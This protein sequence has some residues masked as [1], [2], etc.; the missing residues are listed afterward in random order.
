MLSVKQLSIFIQHQPIVK[1]LNFS[2]KQGECLGL[3]GESGSGK[4]MTAMAIMQLL[5]LGA[6]VSS[7]SQIEFKQQKLLNLSEKHMQ[8]YRGGKIAMIFQDASAAFNPVMTIKQQMCE[9]LQHQKALTHQQRNDYALELL[10]KVGIKQTRRCYHAYPH[11]LSGGMRQRAMIA[12]ALSGKPELIIADEP[13]TAL[14]VTIQAQV[15]DLLCR[16]REEE[17]ISL[18]F[19]THHLAIVSQIADHIAVMKKGERVEYNTVK[20]FFLQ[21]SHAYSKKLLDSV[22]TVDT[23]KA[24]NTKESEKL[25]AVENLKHYFYGK[26]HFNFKR[27]VIKAVDGISF[28][29]NAGKT[30]ALIGESGSGKTTVAKIIARLYRTNKGTIQ[31]ADKSYQHLSP[32]ESRILRHNVQMIFQDPYAALNPRRMVADS[33]MEGVSAQKII[34]NRLEQIA[35]VDQ[36]LK[37]VGLSSEHKW[38]YP[39]EFSGGEKQRICIARALALR[40]KLLILDEPTSALDASIQRQVLNLLRELQEQYKIACLLITHDFSVVSYLADTIA[41]MYQGHIVETGNSHDL[42]KEPQHEYTKQL[43]AATPTLRSF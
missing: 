7:E 12:M 4:S 38:R 6:T 35:M 19:I 42:L 9:S 2:I 32:K 1:S 8:S 3:V 34:T 10:D 13:T 28:S 27:E 25:L 43:I 21:T 16:L 33:I 36:L 37:R 23:K 22:I 18:L 31:L 24:E 14:D 30:L 15:M 20:N 5:P 17:A 26:R 29:L 41:V 40:P 11:E 39:H